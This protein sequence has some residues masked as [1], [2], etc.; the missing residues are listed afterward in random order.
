MPRGVDKSVMMKPC[1]AGGAVYR[2]SEPDSLG[3]ATDAVRVYESTG[4]NSGTWF[5]VNSMMYR[6][7]YLSV[8]VWRTNIF[9]IGGEDERKT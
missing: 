8:A 7:A 6:R 4:A 5:N 3:T 9:A 1:D 2:S